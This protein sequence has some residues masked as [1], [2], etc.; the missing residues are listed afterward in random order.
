MFPPDAEE[1]FSH[2]E[3]SD[4]FAEHIVNVYAHKGEVSN[5]VELEDQF[6][7]FA[8]HTVVPPS[9]PLVALDAR[10]TRIQPEVGFSDLPVG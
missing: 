2:L 1:Y 5:F 6:Y 8:A 4:L 3:H 7:W 9:D 10:A